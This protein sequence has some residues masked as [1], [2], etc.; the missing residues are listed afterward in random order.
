MRVVFFKLGPSQ[1]QI[2][3]TIHCDDLLFVVCRKNVSI[4]KKKVENA[5]HAENITYGMGVSGQ[6]FDVY[7]FRSDVARSSAANEKIVLISGH[8]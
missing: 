2:A 5:A 4:E 8:S 7:D 6:V 1:N 3:F